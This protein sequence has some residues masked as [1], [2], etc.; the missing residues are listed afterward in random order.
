MSQ[1]ETPTDVDGTREF[2]TANQLYRDAFTLARKIFDEGYRPEVILAPWRGGTPV[3]IAVHEFFDYKG[4]PTFHAAI[5]ATSYT[6]I[7][8]R[9]DPVLDQLEPLLDQFAQDA[10]VLV[11]DDIFD[12]GHTLRA[13]TQGL[14]RRTTRVKTAVLYYKPQSNQ[15]EQ[16]PDFYVREVTGWIVFPHELVGLDHD[17]IL[18]KD[19]YLYELLHASGG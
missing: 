17:E 13:I 5:K 12:S 8:Q 9:T 14:A 15:T 3:G 4:V 18:E 11:I 19:P 7:G 2:I 16:V 6:G 1:S 10:E